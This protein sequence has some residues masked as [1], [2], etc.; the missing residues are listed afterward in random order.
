[1]K[2]VL[3]AEAEMWMV[4][5]PYWVQLDSTMAAH[6]FG[7]SADIVQTFPHGFI[8][9]QLFPASFCELGVE[10]FRQELTALPPAVRDAVV[11]SLRDRVKQYGVEYVLPSSL[12]WLLD[13]RS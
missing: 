9:T 5:V 12:L 3:A 8:T 1:L 10:R 11:S 4:R 2:A 7:F 6:W 13:P